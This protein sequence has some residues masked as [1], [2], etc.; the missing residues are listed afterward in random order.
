[1]SDLDKINNQFE[2]AMAPINEIAKAV[3]KATP[4]E[5]RALHEALNK[6]IP[7]KIQ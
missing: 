4:P 2:K 3:E 7:Y 1:M 5:V 6:L